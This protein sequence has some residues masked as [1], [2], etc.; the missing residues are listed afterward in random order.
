MSGCPDADSGFLGG[1]LKEPV[2]MCLGRF[3]PG[4]AREKWCPQ[5]VEMGNSFCQARLAP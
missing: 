5:S 4:E 2:V 1:Q 3:I